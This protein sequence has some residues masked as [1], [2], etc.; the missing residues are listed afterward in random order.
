[1]QIDTTLMS[2]DDK[3]AINFAV[4]RKVKIPRYEF[5]GVD[6]QGQPYSYTLFFKPAQFRAIT[7]VGYPECAT[8]A[9]CAHLVD[10]WNRCNPRGVYSLIDP[11][12][13]E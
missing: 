13:I 12:V 9:N 1:M 10:I 4:H 5:R 8:V 3:D 6:H 2:D 7:I 11:A